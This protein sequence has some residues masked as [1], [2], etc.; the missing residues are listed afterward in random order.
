LDPTPFI[1]LGLLIVGVVGGLLW[2][3]R[4][5]KI[6]REAGLRAV[7]PG[8]GLRWVG[9]VDAEALLG[10][11]PFYR[12]TVSR[13]AANLLEGE[14][15]GRRVRVVD[16]AYSHTLE[17]SASTWRRTLLLFDAP[18]L[19]DCRQRPSL[20][21]PGWT[22]DGVGGRALLGRGTEV[23]APSELGAELA[24]AEALLAAMGGS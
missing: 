9:S 6:D 2:K 8:L 10:P 16:Y 17:D 20:L 22:V 13:G 18:G 7:G 3:V 14:R 5:M 1:L 24:A 11:F 12:E 21:Q 15:L 19:A 4:R 23:V